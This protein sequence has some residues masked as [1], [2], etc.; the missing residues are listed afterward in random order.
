MIGNSLS[1]LSVI[2]Q[3]VNSQRILFITDNKHRRRRPHVKTR[4]KNMVRV[5]LLQARHDSH[6]LFTFSLTQIFIKVDEQNSIAINI[7]IPFVESIR[8]NKLSEI[9]RLL[10]LPL[11]HSRIYTQEMLTRWYI[12]PTSMRLLFRYDNASQKAV[13]YL[14]ITYTT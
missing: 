2:I 1:V 4:L 3:G 13:N 12:G 8:D 10:T 11:F 7:I 9:Y 14:A 5:K 6:G